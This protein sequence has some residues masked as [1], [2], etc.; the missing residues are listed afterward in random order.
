[1]AQRDYLTFE[2]VRE[3]VDYDPQT[4][5]LIW[6]QRPDTSRLGKTWNTKYAG[7]EASIID[8]RGYR[9]LSIDNRPYRAHQ[10]AFLYTFKQWPNKLDHIDGNPLN[11]RISNL[12]PAT[13]FQNTWN[14]R[15]RTNNGSGFKGVS[16]FKPRRT[17]RARITHY[18]KEICLGYYNTPEVAHAAYAKAADKYFGKFARSA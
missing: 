14:Q 9:T 11:N 6:R 10:I 8:N 16:F 2:R 1:M 18:G 12:R 15:R 4:G 3:V 17:W 7:K 5:I 13:D